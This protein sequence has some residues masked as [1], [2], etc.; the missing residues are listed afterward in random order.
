MTR[1]IAWLCALGCVIA[2][3]PSRAGAQSSDSLLA[4]GMRAYRNLEFDLAAWLLRRGVA[5]LGAA[6]APTAERTQGLVYLGAAEL[7]R[8]R[9]DSAA[10]VFRRLIVLDPRFR[11][12]RLVF[13][14]EV[15]TVFE[16]VRM[17]TKTALVVV[18]SDTAIV[19]GKT[20]LRFWVVATSFQ[21]V[22]VSL[23]Y[24]DGAPFR[25]LYTGPIGDSLEVQWD[26]FDAAGG[27][28][29]AR[30][31][32]L[33]V[34]SRDAT[35]GLTGILQV[36]LEV[37]LSRPDTVPWPAPPADSLFL[38]EREKG[39]PAMRAVAGGV[40]LSAA[41]V[42]LPVVV[43]GTDAPGGPR[44]AVAG[45][46][47]LATMLGYVLHRPGRPLP[48]NVRANQARRDAWQRRIAT[49]TEENVRRRRDV[50]VIVRAGPVAAIQPRGP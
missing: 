29:G 3:A 47:G 45:T 15:T 2:S 16:A 35:G 24:E 1:H 26:G 27:T 32:L 41:V 44:L 13:P 4:T 39:G 8:G 36:P 17:Q 28:P 20:A 19:L 5:Q 38:P 9:R 7:F 31:L 50:R 46:I 49:V 23:R 34:A 42:A 37:A 43:G 10:A 11:P 30:R 12:D 14:P 33:R 40:I 25:P 48:G 18:P 21:L 6:D 22:D